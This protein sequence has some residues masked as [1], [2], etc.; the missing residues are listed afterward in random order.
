MAIIIAAVTALQRRSGA[1]DIGI[2]G[3]GY[4]LIDVGQSTNEY[5]PYVLTDPQD[6]V[7]GSLVQQDVELLSLNQ[8][9]SVP[10]NTAWHI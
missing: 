5:D 1:I 8:N 7:T 6:A 2:Y 10:T 3:K 9:Y 4:A